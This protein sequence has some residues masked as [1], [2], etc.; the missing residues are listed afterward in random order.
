MAGSIA[1][2]IAY[3]T[4]DVRSMRLEQQNKVKNLVFFQ[5]YQS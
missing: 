1:T 4:V 5:Q 3:V 2:D